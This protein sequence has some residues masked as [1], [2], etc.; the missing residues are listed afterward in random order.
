MR[1]LTQEEFIEKA[2]KIHGSKY[3]YS[4]V[5]YNGNINKVTIICPIHGNFLQS[6]NKH[7]SHKGCIKCSGRDRLTTEIFIK[8]S[9]IIHNN[10]YDYSLVDYKNNH[11]DVKIICPIH[12]SFFQSP[13]NHFAGKGCKICGLKFSKGEISINKFL[14]NNNIDFTYQKYFDTCRHPESK[15]LMPFDFYL[16]K[17]NIVI[18]YDGEQ[19]Y[20]GWGRTKIKQS[21]EYYQYNDSIKTKYC[22]DNGIKLIRI[23][24]TDFKNI[25]SILEK[26]LLTN[27]N[28]LVEL[29][30]ES[31]STLTH[32]DSVNIRR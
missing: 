3:D 23:K 30:K 29:N 28:S 13:S 26:E 5:V 4:L 2:I 19:H 15:R 31:V 24:Y 22:L 27:R 32:A 10:R 25:E 1:K 18:E 21:K 9:I 20:F 7:L 12:G 6:P 8:R 17:Y 16:E 14:I 11:D